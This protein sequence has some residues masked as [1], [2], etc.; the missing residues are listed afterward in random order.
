MAMYLFASRLSSA[1]CARRATAPGTAPSSAATGTALRCSNC[2]R[3]ATPSPVPSTSGS[4]TNSELKK[5]N[6]K[7]SE[8]SGELRDCS[9]RD[10]PTPNC[11]R[12]NEPLQRNHVTR[13]SV[14]PCDRSHRCD[15][16]VPSATKHRVRFANTFPRINRRKKISELHEDGEILLQ[17]EEM[18]ES[19]TKARKTKDLIYR[20]SNLVSGTLE[21]LIQRLVPTPDYRPDRAFLFAFLLS[22]RMFI[23]PN[24]LLGQVIFLCTSA[25]RHRQH[26]T[27]K[28]D[29]LDCS[30]SRTVQLLAEWMETFPYD[31]RDDR[32]MAHVRNIIRKCA[33]CS[34][35]G[36]SSILQ[37]LLDRLMALE[38]YEEFLQRLNLEQTNINSKIDL[39]SLCSKSDVLAQQLT[40]IELER[41]SYI[42]PEE[43]I[44]AFSSDSQREN[45]PAAQPKNLEAYVTWSNR[46]TYLVATEIVKQTKK[47]KRIKIVD[48]WLNT[49]QCCF[50]LGNFNS[51]MS[52]LSGLNLSAVSRLKRTWTKVDRQKFVMLEKQMDASGDF[53][54]YRLI[55]KTA[56][57]S[58]NSSPEQNSR[59]I[60]P[61]FS[62]F[63]KD[64]FVLQEACSRKLPNGHI[65]FERFWQMAKLVTELITWQQVVCPH[66]RDSTLSHYLQS[67]QL[68]DETEL[69]RASLTCEV[70]VNMAEQEQWNSLK[71]PN[72]NKRKS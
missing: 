66:V 4:A 55:L 25:H 40:I 6:S 18:E 16:K 9:N 54:N 50:N 10:S 14:G 3:L 68:Y 20:D 8:V 24:Q 32:V 22:S 56:S 41:L 7:P 27:N 45:R 1:V 63:L 44:Q 17:E 67:V 69:A 43:F 60:I 61:F 62:L 47:N 34:T 28:N 13:A 15:G 37:T 31:F 39:M 51:L 70:P 33:D 65:N 48:L 49:A 2:S 59:I 29:K 26:S 30:I 57:K 38:R 58:F 53:S 21:A 19:P 64:V 12:E 23:R 5:D 35:E 71:N 11:A 52:I 46:L 42:G 36:V 72:V